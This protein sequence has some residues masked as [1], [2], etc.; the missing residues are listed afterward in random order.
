MSRQRMTW[1]GD[2]RPAPTRRASAHPATPWEGE[3]HPAA[4]PDPEAD[5]YENGDPSSWAEDPHPPP[6]RT[7]VAP[8]VP[9]DDGGYRHPATQPGA[10]AKN[11]SVNV[12]IAAERKAAKC[13]RIAA[14]LLGSNVATAAQRGEK[15]ATDLIEDQALDFMD[16]SD[17]RIAS[18]LLRLEASTVDEETLLRKMLAAENG[19]DE[20]SAEDEESET[21]ASKKASTEMMAAIHS[22]QAEI[23]A[24]KAGKHHMSGDEDALLAEMLDQEKM[25]GDVM[26]EE[27]AMLAEMLNQEKMGGDDMSEEDALLAEM[28]KEAVAPPKAAKPP[29]MAEETEPVM[30]GFEDP[31]AMADESD[32]MGADEEAIL[33]SLFASRSAA[34]ETDEE[35][36]ATASKK[37]DED[38]ELEEEEEELEEPAAKNASALRPQPKKASVGAKTIGSQTRVASSGGNDLGDLARLWASAPDVSKVFGGN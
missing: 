12:R 8:A 7:S 16:L 31:M 22:L 11:A 20:E 19:E 29:I 17:A 1:G 23:E 6:Y 25:S 18:T 21:K 28:L 32:A 27:D 37:A 15:I 30:G 14:A 3:T 36:E 24:L 33:A 13:I 35:S 4:Y 10:P 34:E 5:A 26:S 9:Y 2:G 38:E